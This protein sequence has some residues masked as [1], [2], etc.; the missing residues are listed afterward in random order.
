MKINK[1]LLLI[2]LFV[3]LFRLYFVFQTAYFSDDAS[4]SYLRQLD[5]VKDNLKPMTYDELSYGGKPVLASPLF[6]Y[7]LS[8]F[9]LVP[10]GLK[11]MP[12][13]IISLLVFVVYLL[14][15]WIVND[16]NSALLSSLLAGFMPLSMIETL[17]KISIYF[18]AIPLIFYLIY[19][20]PKMESMKHKIGFF[21]ASL[22][23]SLLD[24]IFIILV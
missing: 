23:I 17:N 8:L 24:P 6:P 11:V 19:S 18:L 10:F 22:L 15:K 12:Q 16:E 7:I 20:I 14:A 4:Y 9:S 5:Y 2:F 1:K 3:F 21:V 13:L